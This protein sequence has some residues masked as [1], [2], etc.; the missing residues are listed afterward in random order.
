MLGLEK[1]RARIVPYSPE[2]VQLFE[3]EEKRL[4]DLVGEYVL[5]IQ[6]VGSTSISGMPAKPILD[7]GITIAQYEDGNNC[8]KPIESLG[9]K[10]RG[11]FGVA[12]RYYYVKGDPRTHHIHMLERDSKEWQRMIFFRDSLRKDKGIA[13]EYA[14]LK[15]RLADQYQN[16]REAYTEGKTGFIKD[17]LDRAKG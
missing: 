12:R 10:Y 17:I 9:Y 3:Q 5:D 6:H 16:D 15:R 1:G 2:W 4:R 8:I 7:I 14:E 13:Q 11:E